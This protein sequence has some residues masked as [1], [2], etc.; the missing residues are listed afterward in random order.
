MDIALQ[1]GDVL[2]VTDMQVDFVSGSLAVPEALHI[3]PVISRYIGAFQARGLPIVATR[4]WHPPDHVS[5]DTCGGPWPVHCVA[6]TRGAELLPALG[7]PRDTHVIDKATRRDREAYS[8][9]AEPPLDALLGRL[10]AR[11]L[12]ACGLATEYCVLNTVRDALH[13]GY[14]V[15]LLVD[16][17]RAVNLLP[18]DGAV[19]VRAMLALGAKALRIDEIEEAAVADG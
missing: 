4:D 5:F 16:A 8:A 12:F 18:E 10:G 1:P 6:G 13:R 14:E 19:A 3:L 11:R 9:F 7:L 17:I 15:F 2:L